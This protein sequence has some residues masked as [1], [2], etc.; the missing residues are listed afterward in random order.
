M[1]QPAP[2]SGNG[3]QIF[4]I[5]W[6]GH[7]Q[8]IRDFLARRAPHVVEIYRTIIISLTHPSYPAAEFTACHFAT[9]FYRCIIDAIRGERGPGKYDFS[10]PILEMG[11]II[12]PGSQ[13]VNGAKVEIPVSAFNKL[14]T[15]IEETKERR[16]AKPSLR[17]VNGVKLASETEADYTSVINR[18][19]AINSFLQARRHVPS[20]P[21]TATDL[22]TI[23]ANIAD[24]EQII[25]SFVGGSSED[26]AV[27]DAWLVSED[28]AE[29]DA[30]LMRIAV[31]A[32]KGHFWSSITNPALIPGLNDRNLFQVGNLERNGDGRVAIPRIPS[33]AFL[34]KNARSNPILITEIFSRVTTDNPFF[35]DFVFEALCAVPKPQMAILC[36]IAIRMVRRRIRPFLIGGYSSALLA[37][38]R[39]SLASKAVNLLDNITFLVKLEEGRVDFAVLDVRDL[40]SE[41]MRSAV[42]T[43]SAIEISSIANV[44]SKRLDKFMKLTH[45]ER[46]SDATGRPAMPLVDY[47]IIWKPTIEDEPGNDLSQ[48]G[49]QL[50]RLLR[51]VLTDGL[52]RSTI[53]M[54]ECLEILGRFNW[55]IFKRIEIHLVAK[56][57]N[58]PAI[59]S[60]ILNRD[61]FDNVN[62]K[63]EMSVLFRRHFGRL[64]EGQRAIVMGWIESGP[65]ARE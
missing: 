31:P 34:A 28:P 21:T 2:P 39:E 58:L 35:L 30:V 55:P 8:I 12:G 16:Q 64:D 61:L 23:Q 57:G 50:I 62:Y 63:H 51:D 60:T 15:L 41:D 44:L 3:E 53:S 11:E 17:L 27:I 22:A 65:E 20:F 29:L 9:E 52:E 54:A 24:L 36:D 49:P 42:L 5:T 32:L 10:S 56:T 14:R 6:T 38:S 33:F 26:K 46:E 45:P 43:V 40:N 7:R 19:D 37:L 25:A 47:S 18:L 13:D 4:P 48:I 59:I 1:N